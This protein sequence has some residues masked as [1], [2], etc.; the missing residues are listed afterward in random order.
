MS[1]MT[2][3]LLPRNLLAQ[4]KDLDRRVRALEM[5]LAA[6]RAVLA[7]PLVIE[8]ATGRVFRLEAEYIDGVATLWMEAVEG[9]GV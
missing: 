9:Q 1:G 8:K 5:A 7:E 6:E 4:M 3:D 2:Q